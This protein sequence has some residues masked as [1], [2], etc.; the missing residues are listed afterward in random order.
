[1]GENVFDGDYQTRWSATGMGQWLQMDLGSVKKIKSI[2][3]AAYRGDTRKTEFEIEVSDDNVNWKKVKTFMT[4][5]ITTEAEEYA[6]DDIETRYLRFVGNG[7][8]GGGGWTS[9][10][11]IGLISAE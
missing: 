2:L 5:G 4:S 7:P 6:L 3:V 11:E 8:D 1:M 9:I 10:S